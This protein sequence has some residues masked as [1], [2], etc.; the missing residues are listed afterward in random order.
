METFKNN[1]RSSKYYVARNENSTVIHAG[2]LNPGQ[3]VTTGQSILEIYETKEEP[4]DI[5]GGLVE[6]FLNIDDLIV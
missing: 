4:L 2:K 3:V 6:E 5:Y 1:S